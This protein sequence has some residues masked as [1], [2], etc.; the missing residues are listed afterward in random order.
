MIMITTRSNMRTLRM[1]V[2][3][4]SSSSSSSTMTISKSPY[5]NKMMADE[6]MRARMR[7]MKRI[8]NSSNNS[9]MLPMVQLNRRMKGSLDVVMAICMPVMSLPMST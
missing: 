8:I 9:R 1:V 7:I 4:S 2:T 3:N 5:S 6:M